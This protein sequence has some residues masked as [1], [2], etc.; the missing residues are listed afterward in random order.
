M[1]TQAEENVFST[2]FLL[3]FCFRIVGCLPGMIRF[4]KNR[5][6]LFYGLFW[7]WPQIFIILGVFWSVWIWSWGLGKNWKCVWALICGRKGC[8]D[9]YLFWLIVCARRYFFLDCVGFCRFNV[10]YNLCIG[11]TMSSWEFVSL[12]VRFEMFVRLLMVCDVVC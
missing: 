1:V 6:L 8:F 5:I 4:P 9:R 10:C 12:F 3:W 11:W 7:K 2:R